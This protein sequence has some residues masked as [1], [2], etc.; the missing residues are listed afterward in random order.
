LDR[1]DDAKTRDSDGQI[2]P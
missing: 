2:Q 1:A